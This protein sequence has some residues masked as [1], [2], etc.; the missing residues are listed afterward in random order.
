[1]VEQLLNLI[2]DICGFLNLNLKHTYVEHKLWV[3]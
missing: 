1:M 3:Y 2:R